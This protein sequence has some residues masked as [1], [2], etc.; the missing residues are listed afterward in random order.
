MVLGIIFPDGYSSDIDVIKKNLIFDGFVPSRV[1]TNRYGIKNILKGEFEIK[2][3]LPSSP[4]IQRYK[5][6]DFYFEKHTKQL[7]KRYIIDNCDRA[8]VFSLQDFDEIGLKE[9]AW[10]RG[11]VSKFVRLK[12]PLTEIRRD[13]YEELTMSYESHIIEELHNIEHERIRRRTIFYQFSEL[14]NPDYPNLTLSVYGQQVNYKIIGTDFEWI[15]SKLKYSLDEKTLESEYLD[16]SLNYKNQNERRL[17]FENR[18]YT[19]SYRMSLKEAFEKFRLKN[20]RFIN[21]G[22]FGRVPS[23]CYLSDD[24]EN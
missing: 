2:T 16:Y 4:E 23:L 6:L 24:I 20:E 17:L 15:E 9:L 21:S 19:G 10:K 1:I 13:G 12:K 14:Q 5:T 22:S 7:C 18:G 11:V 8:I 3:I